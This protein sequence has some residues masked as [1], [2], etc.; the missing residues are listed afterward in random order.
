MSNI[1]PVK[2]KPEVN[3][4][5]VEVL[6]NALELAKTGQLLS[7]KIAGTMLDGNIFTD[8]SSTQNAILELAAITRLV[9]RVQLAMDDNP[10]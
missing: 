9:H 8:F 6:E 4:D 2:F 5:L 10:L 7:A 3:Q 1:V